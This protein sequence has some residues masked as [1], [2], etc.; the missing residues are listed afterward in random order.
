[1][2]KTDLQNNLAM[3]ITLLSGAMLFATLFMGYAIY[4][5]SADV[6]P[7]LGIPKV[8]LAIPLLSTIIIVLSSWFAYQIKV[9]V[10]LNNFSKGHSHLNLTLAL[11]TAFLLAQSYLWFHM[12]SSGVFVGTSGIFG[13]V[14]YGFTWIHALHMVAGL[15]SLVYLKI[16]L[17]PTTLNVLQKTINVEKFW[18]FLGVIWI[19]MFLTLFVL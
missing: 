19:I 13:S 16:V 5:T 7:P 15:G 10:K 14:L 1:V 11:G 2:K 9:Q 3:T 8:S 6:W 12:K 18:H 4:R 17:R